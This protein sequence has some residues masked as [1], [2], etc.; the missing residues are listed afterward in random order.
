MDNY[1]L[2]NKICSYF[3]NKNI[4]NKRNFINKFIIEYKK[5]I[6]KKLCYLI[7]SLICLENINKNIININEILNNWPIHILFNN[8]TNINTNVIVC[9]ITNIFINCKKFN[10]KCI[11]QEIYISGGP[12]LKNSV[13]HKEIKY[14]NIFISN[15]YELL[16]SKLIFIPIP[17]F[18]KINKTK[19]Y[20][21]IHK[22]IHKCLNYCK[23]NKLNS[24][25][26]P[27]LCEYYKRYNNNDFIIFILANIKEWFMI[28]NY[29]IN[30]VFC[31]N[32]KFIYNTYKQYYSNIFK[33][34]DYY[35]L[36]FENIYL[37]RS[38]ES[39]DDT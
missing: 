39:D 11:E 20:S 38:S 22:S 17:F 33:N 6:P 35:K 27:H 19:I 25:V 10:H 34:N 15:T 2:I 37:F 13:F 12:S 29:Y 14:N 21:S 18:Q 23:E 16:P 7:D 32:N 24:I 1:F 3:K 31:I 36:T 26:F 28:N 30:I 9:P 4:D 5:K 8:I